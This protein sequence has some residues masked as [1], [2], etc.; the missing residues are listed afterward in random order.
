MYIF[1]PVNK[2]L[3][4]PGHLQSLHKATNPSSALG[5][6]NIAEFMS[7]ICINLCSPKKEVAEFANCY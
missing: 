1:C 3:I 5:L 7:A 6:S 2:Q 4:L